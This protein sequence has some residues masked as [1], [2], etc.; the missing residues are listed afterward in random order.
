LSANYG[1]T[2]SIAVLVGAVRLTPDQCPDQTYR[3]L[4]LDN[5]ARAPMLSPTF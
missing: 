3:G 2:Q 1:F 4:E 5:G